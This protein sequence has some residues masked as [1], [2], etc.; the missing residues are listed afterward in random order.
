MRAINR[1]IIH[2]TATKLFADTTVDDLYRWHVEERGWSHI[3]YHYY[4]DQKGTIHTC[5]PI[6]MIGAHALGHNEDSIG[7]CLEGGL[8]ATTGKPEDTRTMEQRES[9]RL[10][11]SSLVSLYDIK[12]T[13][14]IGHNEISNRDCPC[15]DVASLRQSLHMYNPL[16]FRM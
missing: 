10:L 7:I 4:I 13:N 12:V 1:I 9:L 11:L 15:F 3:G 14:I 16:L 8:S 2:C 5:R 6:E